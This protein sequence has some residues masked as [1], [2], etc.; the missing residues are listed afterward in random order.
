M[1]RRSDGWEEKL[2]FTLK[3]LFVKQEIPH[4]RT[5]TDNGW[6]EYFGYFVNKLWLIRNNYSV[7]QSGQFFGIKRRR[8]DITMR[9]EAVSLTDYLITI[10]S[11]LEAQG[12]KPVLLAIITA[13][14]NKPK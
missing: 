12:N 2:R 4:T 8:K 6:K 10:K 1:T 13:Y 9:M 7:W 5:W 3:K 11:Q 14:L